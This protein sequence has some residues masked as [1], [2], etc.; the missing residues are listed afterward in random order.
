[1]KL[2]ASERRKHHGGG[3]LL[4]SADPAQRCPPGERVEIPGGALVGHLG[5]EEPGRQRVDPNRPASRPLRRQVPSQAEQSR[6]G[7]GVRRLWEFGAREPDDARHVDD[8]A[9]GGHGSGGGLRG[10]VRPHEIEVEH[11]AELLRR[12]P[13]CRDSRRDA[14]I[15]HQAVEAAKGLRG[16]SHQPL[17]VLHD[18]DVG[19]HHERLA[20]EAL[21]GGRRRLEHL[22]TP[23]PD[24][25]IGAGLRHRD[26]HGDAQPR[27][28]P[29]HD[30]H[31]A[32]EAERV[33]D[34]CQRSSPF[35]AARLGLRASPSPRSLP[36]RVARSRSRRAGTVASGTGSWGGRGKPPGRPS[37]LRA[38]LVARIP[39]AA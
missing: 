38:L 5:F 12:L 36:G 19:R 27:G 11:G 32:L 29:G 35:A 39:P 7:G 28:R 4:R 3:D 16:A 33:Q 18:G 22:S 23:G 20:A 9:A 2:A 6:F 24:D 34:A 31:A 10:P 25:H 13:Q 26:R 1:M 21:D 15:V 14:G 8:R 30:H 17:A 37:A